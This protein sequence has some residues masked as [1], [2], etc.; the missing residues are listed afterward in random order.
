MQK[1]CGKYQ[2]TIELD[3]DYYARIELYYT[4]EGI[5]QLFYESLGTDVEALCVKDKNNLDL[6]AFNILCNES[7]CSETNYGLFDP[8]Q[9]K[10]LLEP[11][12]TENN[13][14]QLIS[15]LGFIPD[16][17]K[18]NF[19]CI[20]QFNA[21]NTYKG[22]CGNTTFVVKKDFNE[23]YKM[24]YLV[25][26]K[27][28]QFYIPEKELLDVACVDSIDN[29]KY[30]LLQERCGG[31]ACSETG[32]YRIIDPH[33]RAFLL[34]KKPFTA[35]DEEGMDEFADDLKGAYEVRRFNHEE[36]NVAEATQILG[37]APP[38]R[39]INN[40]CCSD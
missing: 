11:Y 39:L 31:S 19:C 40:F 6:L 35:E 38:E 25:G 32:E 18:D 4:K 34:G 29:K 21:L 37:Y 9:G 33:T 15:I 30:L 2:Y 10:F 13:M 17:D 8:A 24:F 20:T 3:S 12:K 16:S 26:Q 28:K 7:G 22:K 1:Q 14:E 27:E 23:G 36:K 5:R